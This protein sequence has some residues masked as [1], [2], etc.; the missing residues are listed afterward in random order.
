M[1][2][3]VWTQG[4][5]KNSIT[6]E[7]MVQLVRVGSELRL[8]YKAPSAV[9]VAVL[10]GTTAD[11]DGNVSFEKEALYLDQLNKVIERHMRYKHVI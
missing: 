4:G 10:R 2:S 6:T 7:D 9:H 3:T 8:W 11:L 5:K 1:L